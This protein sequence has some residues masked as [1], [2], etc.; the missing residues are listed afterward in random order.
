MGGKLGGS[1]IIHLGRARVHRWKR[2]S[3]L[4][5]EWVKG[6]DGGRIT[7]RVD[8]GRFLVRA[9]INL[10]DE[11]TCSLEVEVDKGDKG[12][13]ER[14]NW[15]FKDN[16]IEIPKKLDLRPSQL[17]LLR[18][19]VLPRTIITPLN[20]PNHMLIR[21]EDLDYLSNRLPPMIHP[22]PL[23]FRFEVLTP[24]IQSSITL[25]IQWTKVHIQSPNQKEKGKVKVVTM[26]KEEE[27]G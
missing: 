17:L 26:N 2:G 16:L 10:M 22:L 18:I 27:W 3:G 5:R 1:Y 13:K 19:I 4:M 23:L 14:L 8:L 11:V 25:R 12:D 24:Q 20:N 9:I 7:L 6:L 15:D 21:P